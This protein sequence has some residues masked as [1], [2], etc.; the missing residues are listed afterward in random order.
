[1]L[2]TSLSIFTPIWALKKLF[3]IFLWGLIGVKLEWL[4]I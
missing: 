1:M 2:E 3:S 4:V